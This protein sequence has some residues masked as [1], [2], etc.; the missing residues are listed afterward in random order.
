MNRAQLLA[1]ALAC[2][3]LYTLIQAFTLRSAPALPTAPCVCPAPAAVVAPPTPPTPPP[4]PPTGERSAWCE[5]HAVRV[6]HQTWKTRE[7]PAWAEGIRATW[8]RVHGA[9]WAFRVYG[10]DDNRALVRRV[11]PWALAAYDMA[12]GVVKSDLTRA[13]YLYEYGGVYADM[14]VEA[15]KPLDALLVQAC[16]EQRNVILARMDGP[17]SG[18]HANAIPNAIMASARPG[19]PFWPFCARMWVSNIVAREGHGRAETLAGPEALK[20]CTEKWTQLF[21]GGSMDR[22]GAAPSLTILPKGVLYPYSWMH[23]MELVECRGEDLD[24]A[25]CKKKLAKELETAYTMVYWRHSWGN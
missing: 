8:L 4:T 11:F 18:D 3:T 13:A 20:A 16:V 17:G 15:L 21:E 9:A 19:E 25:K 14:D 24:P 23:R 10:D 5:A 7:V 12:R 1:L 6:L 2:A 22:Q